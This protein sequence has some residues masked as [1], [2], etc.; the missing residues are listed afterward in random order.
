MSLQSLQHYIIYDAQHKVLICKEHQY[1]ITN[2]A[3]HF[4]Q[5][6]PNMPTKTRLQIRVAT[7]HLELTN[8]K[9]IIVPSSNSL[10]IDGLELSEDGAKCNECEYVAGTFGTMEEHCR[11]NHD[12]KAQDA[13]MWTKQAV[14]TFYPGI[15]SIT[16]F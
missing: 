4:Q 11:N 5:N 15:T 12:W 8:P 9:D 2:V 16:L 7:Q 10:P 14:Q 1:G 3:R 6:H 13:L